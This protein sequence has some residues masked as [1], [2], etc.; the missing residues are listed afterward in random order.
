M[1]DIGMRGSSASQDIRFKDK[2]AQSIK[3]TKFPKHF[4]EKVDLRKV[5]ISVLRPWIAEKITALLKVEDDIVVEY[6]FGMLED[7]DN[8]TPDPKQMQVSLVGFMDKFGAAAFMDQ[9]WKLLLSAQKTVGGVP[10]EFI[11]AKK[12]ELQAQQALKQSTSPT[13]RPARPSADE[14]LNADLDPHL[15]SDRASPPRGYQDR[16]Y[17]SR[18][19]GR[20]RDRRYGFKDDGYGRRGS[21]G[22][23]PSGVNRFA[24]R[25]RDNGYAS[26]AAFKGEHPPYGRDQSPPYSR[27]SARRSPPRRRPTPPRR[28]SPSP[29]RRPRSVSR[30]ISPPLRAERGRP[31]PRTLTPPSPRAVQNRLSP[32]RRS[33]SV[34]RSRSPDRRRRRVSPSLSPY[35]STGS[36]SPRRRRSYG[37]SRNRNRSVTPQM[38]N[39]RDYTPTPSRSPS[40]RSRSISPRREP[41]RRNNGRR[42]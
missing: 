2:V 31:R 11:E 39:K 22:G 38:R 3:A 18:N 13:G 8:P 16:D 33:V 23:R 27:T 25:S 26:R 21:R 41:G 19:Q 15:T 4:S 30:S 5:N 42:E 24:D 32:H 36:S 7:N 34:S 29:Q 10:A 9:L 1:A 40:P 37:S 12:A 35:H 17:H 28:L 14:Y 20:D 6:V